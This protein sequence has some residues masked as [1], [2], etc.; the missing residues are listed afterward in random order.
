[1]YTE[2]A[3]RVWK[4][5]M[6][7]KLIAADRDGYTIFQIDESLFN[8]QDALRNCWSTLGENYTYFQVSHHQ[9]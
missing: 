2:E 7:E 4:K 3:I 8:G 9:R 6:Q 5:D 1:M